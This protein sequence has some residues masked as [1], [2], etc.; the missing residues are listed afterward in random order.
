MNF[1]KSDYNNTMLCEDWMEI[2]LNGLKGRRLNLVRKAVKE[3]DILYNSVSN[4]PHNKLG[5]TV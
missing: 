3:F 5:R 2:G 4:T 1:R